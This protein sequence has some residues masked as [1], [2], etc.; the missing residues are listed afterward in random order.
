ML[1]GEY[2]GDF[3]VGLDFWGL[4]WDGCLVD[5]YYFDFCCIRGDFNYVWNVLI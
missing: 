2:G 3:R 5:Y 1:Y 4:G